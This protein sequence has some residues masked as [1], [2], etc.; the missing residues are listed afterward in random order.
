[1]YYPKNKIKTGLHTNGGEYIFIDSQKEYVGFYYALYNGTFYEGKSPTKG[2][3]QII[4]IL[5]D[6]T[7]ESAPFYPTENPYATDHST[8]GSIVPPDFRINSSNPELNNKAYIPTLNQ[9]QNVP[10]PSYRSPLRTDYAIGQFIRYF[11]KKANEPVFI[12]IDKSTYTSLYNKNQNWVQLY[13]PFQVYWLIAGD[14]QKVIQA[15][16]TNVLR[17]EQSIQVY[18]FSKYIEKFGGYDKFYF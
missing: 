16:K 6:K 11:C 18:G 8:P 13:I 10:I 9:I 17:K 2:N 4:P 1:M 7:R 3:K 14:Y 5:D 15:N 12:E